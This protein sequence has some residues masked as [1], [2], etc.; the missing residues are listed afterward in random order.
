MK[1]KEIIKNNKKKVGAAAMAAMLLVGGAT[2]A[3]FTDTNLLTNTFTFG[4]VDSTLVE[5][6]W[7]AADPSEHENL[8][9]NA[10]IAKDPKV[11]NNGSLDFYTFIKVTVPVKD[12]KVASADG[13]QVTSGKTDMFSWTANSGWTLVDTVDNGDTKDYIYAWG[14]AD[15]MTK[16]APSSE[17]GTLFDSVKI[18]NIIEGQGIEGTAL[19]LIV[20]DYSIQTTD[21]TDAD[22]T[23]PTEVWKIVSGQ[24]EAN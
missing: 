8:A 3:Y 9:P 23:N 15:A 22:T 1:A 13:T 24:Q 6:A 10:V 17:T 16:V 14:S 12:V 7:D 21:L 5:T 18:A 4:S 20:K 19:D 2:Y 11:V